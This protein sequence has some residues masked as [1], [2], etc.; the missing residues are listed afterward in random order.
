MIL[1][2]TLAWRWFGSCWAILSA[3]ATPEKIRNNQ[4]QRAVNH[5]KSELENVSKG[6]VTLDER[7]PV[8]SQLSQRQSRFF[9]NK[10]MKGSKK[11]KTKSTYQEQPS[12]LKL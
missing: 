6:R 9:E 4:K 2:K 10:G 5:D 1:L 8:F 12:A 11:C 7:L 3:K